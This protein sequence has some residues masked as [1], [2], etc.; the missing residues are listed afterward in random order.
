MN[1]AKASF[2]DQLYDRARDQA[3]EAHRILRELLDSKPKG[4]V[5]PPG[6]SRV[7]L[8]GNNVIAQ[9]PIDFKSGSAVLTEN[10]NAIV[11][12]VAQLLKANVDQLQGITIVGHTDSRGNANANRTISANRARAVMQAL[13]NAGIPQALMTAEGRGPDQPIADNSTEEGRRANRRVDIS[14]R[15]K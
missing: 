7:R 13:V 2:A 9:P 4:L 8:D 15:T 12:E 5:I 3:D 10:G 14:L 1:A 11:A 6:L